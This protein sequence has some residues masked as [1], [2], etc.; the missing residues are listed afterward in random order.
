[1]AVTPFLKLQKPPFDTIP[2]D[3]AV[4]GNMDT[5]DAFISR[6]M[7]VPNYV[8]AWTNST[9][10]VSG[11]N[12]LD[13]TNAIIYQCAITHTSS[14]TPT[15]F[16]Q[17]RTTYPTYWVATQNV[18]TGGA[19]NTVL[20]I[21]E[22]TPLTAKAGDLWWDSLGGQLY[23]MY[24]DGNSLQWVIANNQ[25]GNVGEAPNDGSVYGR[26]M[27]A[28]TPISQGNVGRNLIHNSMFNIAQRGNG[29]WTAQSFMLDRW[30]NALSGDAVSY[31]P[32]AATD[33]V[34]AAV[35][36][37]YAQTSLRNVFT[38]NAATGSYSYVAQSIENLHRLSGKTVI[39]SFYALRA[40]ATQVSVGVNMQASYGTGGSPSPAN[41]VG[42]GV[43][44]PLTTVMTRYFATFTIPSSVGMTYGTN[45][46]SFAQVAFW[47][48]SGATNAGAAGVGVQSGTIQL[49]GVQ[50]EV[51][52]P[53]QTQPTPLEKPD[54]QQDLAKCQRFYQVGDF[55]WVGQAPTS[56]FVGNALQFTTAFRA[57]PTINLSA[58]TYT[59]LSA[60]SAD[61]ISLAGARFIATSAT[62]GAAQFSTHWTASADL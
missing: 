15:T 62:A 6:Y 33:A 11:Q 41:W 10:Y 59:N 46:D 39:V 19:G 34:R 52:A 44:F 16:A 7:A 17:D 37:E 14:A 55:N 5:I 53:G 58:Q 8:G 21:A 54:P 24:N 9:A 28:W 27:S 18:I 20:T 25:A 48:S 38:G 2:W 12:V 1:M 43:A 29:P 35:G 13:I 42:N 47:Y 57:T 3:Q 30:F 61:T 49:W 22:A 60:A 4:N 45:N 23:V 40:A 51:A 50:C 26:R 31:A 32:F 56:Y 36:D